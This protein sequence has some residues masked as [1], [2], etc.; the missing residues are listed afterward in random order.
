MKILIITT[1]IPYPPYRGDKLKIFNIAKLLSINNSV[2]IL[3]FLRNNNQKKELAELEKYGIETEFVKLSIIVSI[4]QTIL[5][6]WG[7]LPFQLAFFKSS[8]MK[9]KIENKVKYENID[10][11]YYHLIRSAQF[12]YRNDFGFKPLN[13]LDFTDAVS[14]YLKR[15]AEIES[16]MLKKYFINIEQNRVEKYERTAE[17]FHS[18]FVCS[19]VDKDFLKD[20]GINNNVNI[21][22]NGIDTGYFNSEILPFE[23]NRIIFTG[24][25]PYYA[26]YDAAIYFTKQ[27]FP[28][29]L[30][31]IP[32]AE[33]YIVGQ[34]PPRRIRELKSNNIYITGFV[35]DIKAEYLKSA[36]NVAPMRFG[37]GTLNKVLESIAL[38]VPVVATSMAVNGLPKELSKYIFVADNSIDFAEKIREILQNP[39]IRNDLME[40]GKNKIKKILSW[41]KIVSDFEQYLLAEIS[42]LN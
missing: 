25:M 37:A 17:K 13:V 6:I 9:R 26:N 19:E 24:N 21:L 12:V 2:T 30:K 10:V 38:G 16:N 15:F 18:L 35:K 40:E 8:K 39:S 42:H 28:L 11:V 7:N 31:K 41:D 22:P 29:L 5:A 36:V 27:I 4:I 14:L 23:K 34:K 32:E 3:T 1:R 33:F 20:K